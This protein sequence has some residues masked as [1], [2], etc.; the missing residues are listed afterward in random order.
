MARSRTVFILCLIGLVAG[1]GPGED[2]S[3]P[4]S[5]VKSL[6]A[7]LV[8]GSVA[9]AR[10]AV[11]D[12]KQAAVLDEMKSLILGVMAAQDAATARF[13]DGGSSVSGGLPSMDDIDKATETIDGETATLAMQNSDKSV[14]LKKIAGKWKVDL[15]SVL[16]INPDS[17]D[18]AKRVLTS[19]GK[20]ATATAQQIKN[21]QFKSAQ[22]ADDAL[23][24]QMKLAVVTEMFKGMK[25]GG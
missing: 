6:Y 9:S 10:G 24:Q 7:A 25:F 16:G 22:A 13:G 19:V 14:R 12:E 23:Q 2:Y 15:F 4:K 11:C 8:G 18:T 21:G 5:A 17:I 1:C 20:A 3:T